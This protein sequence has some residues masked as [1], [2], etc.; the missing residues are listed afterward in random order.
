MGYHL[1]RSW[2]NPR[3]Q[4]RRPTPIRRQPP[5]VRLRLEAFEA[6]DLPS[7]SIPLSGYI[8]TPIGPSPIVNSQAPGG[9]AATGRVNH[10]AVVPSTNV[11]FAAPASGGLWRSTDGSATWQEIPNTDNLSIGAMA[12]IDRPSATVYVTSSG[13]VLK[14]TDGGNTFTQISGS[15]GTATRL[16]ATRDP[17]NPND[18]T[19]DILYAANFQVSRSVDGGATWTGI[20]G[21]TLP[22]GS[23]TDVVVDQTNPDLVYA[24]IGNST[25]S[26]QNG[27]YRSGD[28]RS[29]TPTWS[30]LIGGSQFLPG[31]S[32]VPGVIRIAVAPTLPSTIFVSVSE[33]KITNQFTAPNQDV[34]SPSGF[35]GMFRSTDSGA[36]WTYLANTPDFIGN[37][38]VDNNVLA[39]DPRSPA[40][41][42][43]QV[44]YAAGY[45][46]GGNNVVMS[47][48]SGNTWTPIGVGANGQGPYVNA[49]ESTFD[50]QGRLILTT[51][52]GIYRLNSTSPVL[53]SSLNGTPGPNALNVVYIDGFAIDPTNPDKAV[54]NASEPPVRI[55]DALL[56]NDT[57][58]AGNAAYGWRTGG[59]GGAVDSTTFGNVV[60]A[61][62]VIYNPFNP[63]I[64]YRSTFWHSGSPLRVSTDGGQTWS[65]IS[66]GVTG[67]PGLPQ[68]H[69]EDALPL[70]IDRNL[71]SRIYTGYNKL[72]ISADNGTTWSPTISNVTGSADIPDLPTTAVP[73]NDTDGREVLIDSI[74]SERSDVGTSA[75][76]DFAGFKS[77]TVTGGTLLF[78]ATEAGVLLNPDGTPILD[79]MTN[80][81]QRAF[82]TTLWVNVVPDRPYNA[83]KTTVDDRSWAKVTNLPTF[84][85]IE[86][87]VFDPA[88]QQTV[89]IYTR[90]GQVFRGDNIFYTSTRV[91]DPLSSGN[92]TIRGSVSI[93][94][95]NLTGNIPAGGLPVFKPVA[96]ALDS[97]VATSSSD[98]ILYV[99]TNSGVWKLSNPGAAYGTGNPPVWTQVGLNPTTGATTLPNEPVVA[100]SM[101]TTTGILAAATYGRGVYEIQIRGLIRGTVFEDLNGNGVQDP[102]EPVSAGVTVRVVNADTNVEIAS[103]VT[104]VNGVYQFRSLTSSAQTGTNYRIEVAGTAGVFQ[105][106]APAAFTN[107]TEQTTADGNIDPV[108]GLR[109]PTA[110]VGFFRAGAIRGSVF[111]DLNANGVQDANENG[112]AGFVVYIDRNNNKTRDPGEPFT[113]TAAD[114]SYVFDATN[115][116]NGP[117]M[118]NGI[119]PDVINGDPNNPFSGP[120]IIR[121]EPQVGFQATVPPPASA[122]GSRT[123]SITSGQTVSAGTGFGEVRIA[124]LSGR[125]FE[126]LNANGVEDAGEPAA[127]AGFTVR[128][129]NTT[130]SAVQ[131][132]TT[133]ADGTYTFRSLIPG[134]Y[135]LTQV[136]LAGWTRTTADPAVITVGPTDQ[137][138]GFDFGNFHNVSVGG[139][140]FNDTNGDGAFAVGEPGLSG[141]TVLLFNA[142]TNTQITQTNTDATGAFAFANV[143]PGRYYVREAVPA[144]WVQ[145]TTNPAAV[146][147]TSGQNPAGVTFGNFKLFGVSGT[148][149][150]DAD[151]NG[152]Q[153]PTDRGFSGFVV[154]VLK[155]GTVVGQAT[156]ATDGTYSFTNLGPGSYTV[157]E[158]PRRGYTL[159]Q[160]GGTPPAYAFTG[161]SGTD[162]TGQDF[163]NVR[164]S[165]TVTALDAGGPPLVT[166]RDVNSNTILRTFNAYATT[167]TGGVRV[168]VGYFNSDTIPDIVVAT[169][170]GGGPHIRVFDGASLNSPSGPTVLFEFM[171]YN[172]A[173]TG[174]IY[175]AVGDVNGDGTDDIITGAGAGGGPHV[176]AFDGKALA[177]GLTPDQARIRSFY[178]YAP[179]FL[180]G[181]RVAAGD[182]NG[183][184]KADIIVGAGPGGGPHVEVFDGSTPTLGPAPKILTSFYAYA[185]TFTGGVFVASG[186]LNAD[187]KADI[188]T[189]PGQGGGPHVRAFDGLSGAIL[190]SFQA[191]PTFSGSG[192]TS[193]ARVASYDVNLDGIDDLIISGGQG[194]SSRVRILN[195]ATL[196]P[197]FPDFFTT[198]PAF[199]GGVFVG[200][201]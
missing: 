95:T 135:Q 58:G 96:L 37:T 48:D 13:G 176:Q 104:D 83:D 182:V 193:G 20:N 153:D 111:E 70:A 144:G 173:F 166:V 28:A 163:G 55:H 39:V 154:Q 80:A 56:F 40:N 162:Q 108:T 148:A 156:S 117:G 155:G 87:V 110:D 125:A 65:D 132:V 66:G 84:S 195:G 151:G 26:P 124:S 27:V 131:T 89:Y 41:P 24:A 192:W 11:M 23:V 188:I 103:T 54:A 81:R 198:D 158:K 57:P 174:G 159:T 3:L 92:F 152:I 98:D 79:T 86:Q 113:T 78:A 133:A 10:V 137:L 164:R 191:F 19:K 183:D 15:I 102:N 9:L 69:Y 29:A 119:G 7:S 129:T 67:L 139:T 189:G 50:Q 121:V 105:T 179:G 97:G 116:V 47:T 112:L 94:W 130:T 25:G 115:V 75:S 161:Q 126:D 91:P 93:T 122:G 140:V 169:G 199:L 175:L 51:G 120:Y 72:L 128:L 34:V 157:V 36:N 186:D 136:A 74:G 194:Q 184:G 168:A 146:T 21:S 38:G 200:G 68:S 99:G 42:S 18:P 88:N 12:V 71:P 170:A 31:S 114:G 201:R 32:R 172:P 142:T 109:R 190:Q 4:R 33:R 22:G 181:V 16:V 185:S 160:P 73:D 123:I 52:G 106:P 6:R 61:G 59:V 45:Q 76:L 77:Y 167:Y 141:F 30:L 197:L 177:Q 127:S 8:W 118:P 49:Q 5:P 138:T 62:A 60:G 17:L 14:S 171:A 180:G 178:A 35:L 134:T 85:Q 90:S 46:N 107:F 145:T 63:N 43:Q 165:I 149:Y 100:L 44:L 1:L 2:L 143:G 82:G 64:V 101:S 187:G 196:E 147:L 150:I 53:W